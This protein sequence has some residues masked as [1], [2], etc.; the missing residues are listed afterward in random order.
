MIVHNLASGVLFT[1]FT[2]ARRD[3]RINLDTNERGGNNFFAK[4]LYYV[5]LRDVGN[6]IISMGII[7]GQN[8]R[9]HFRR[10]T[11][12]SNGNVATWVGRNVSLL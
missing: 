2:I 5:I 3:S 1:A 8:N 4:G 10:N 11:T 7:P 6:E 12:Q 9:R